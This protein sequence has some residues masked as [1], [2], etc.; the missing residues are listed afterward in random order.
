M[1]Q[2]PTFGWRLSGG[3]LMRLLIVVSSV[4]I[5]RLEFAE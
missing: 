2:R 3:W 1:H 4:Q 5:W